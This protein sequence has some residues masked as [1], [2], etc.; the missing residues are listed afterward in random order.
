MASWTSGFDYHLKQHNSQTY[1]PAVAAPYSFD[2][3]LKQHNSQ[4]NAVCRSLAQ[5]FDYHLKQHN[6]Q[7]TS[8]F[9]TVVRT[10]DY[11]LKQHNSQTLSYL[12]PANVM[13]DYHLKQHNSQT[14]NREQRHNKTPC[15]FR[16]HIHFNP[17]PVFLQGSIHTYLCQTAGF[18]PFPALRAD[19][20]PA[21]AAGS[22]DNGPY[23]TS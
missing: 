5:L 20:I 11:H 15:C 18:L 13:F 17:I 6:S 10:F 3:H 12:L 8:P 21:K 19:A 23:C 9:R 14:S 22:F 4:T 2:Y 7:T 1:S 16:L